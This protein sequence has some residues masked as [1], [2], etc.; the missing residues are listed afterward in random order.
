MPY[1]DREK[2]KEYMRE[3]MKRRHQ[4]NKDAELARNK[5]YRQQNKERL[6]LYKKGYYRQNKEYWKKYYKNLHQKHLDRIR[7]FCIKLFGDEIF[8]DECSR[9][10]QLEIETPHFHHINPMV[11]LFEISQGIRKTDIEIENEIKKCVILCDERCH[12]KQH[13]NISIRGNK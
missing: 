4:N 7:R 1:K 11:K 13:Y 12:R 9:R 6:S 2:Q 8:C 10:I 5:R 3:Y